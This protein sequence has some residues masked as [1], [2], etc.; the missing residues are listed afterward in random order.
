MVNA[1][2]L[3]VAALWAKEKALLANGEVVI[4]PVS[5]ALSARRLWST[6]TTPGER[7]TARA[8]LKLASR[9]VSEAVLHAH[10]PL[11]DLVGCV[12]RFL[13]APFLQAVRDGHIRRPLRPLARLLSLAVGAPGRAAPFLRRLCD[14]RGEREFGEAEE[15]QSARLLQRLA[16]RMNAL[17]AASALGECRWAWREVPRNA[18]IVCLRARDAGIAGSLVAVLARRLYGEHVHPVAALAAL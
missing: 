10:I 16:C 11:A 13:P 8:T 18:R 1:K 15:L 14:S 6:A 17:D 7:R 3:D 9:A 4:R 12:A 5:L 2:D